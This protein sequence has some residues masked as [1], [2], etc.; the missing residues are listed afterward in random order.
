[1]TNALKHA[2]PDGGGE[3]RVEAGT[4]A[5]G[6]LRLSVADDGVGLPRGFDP[7]TSMRKSLGMR[8]IHGLSRQLGGTL[9]VGARVMGPASA[10]TC[11]RMPVP[12][13]REARGTLAGD[14]AR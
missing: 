6:R 3:I 8:I 4:D 1:M 9:T 2:Y 10:S 5:A 7:A 14:G 11:R 13:V 12:T